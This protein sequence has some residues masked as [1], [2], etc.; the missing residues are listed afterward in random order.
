MIGPLPPC[1]AYALRGC[2]LCVH[3]TGPATQR[4]CTQPTVAPHGPVSVVHAR[5]NAGPCGPEAVHL[6]FGGLTSPQQG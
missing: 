6:T 1:P 5:S 4:R 3:G 2:A